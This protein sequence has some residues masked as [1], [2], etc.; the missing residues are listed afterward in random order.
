M[1]VKSDLRFNGTLRLPITLGQPLLPS[2][3]EMVRA[4]ELEFVLRK[5]DYRHRND[6]ATRRISQRTV[7]PGV[8][9]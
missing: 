1:E 2:C 5:A 9:E 6:G 8:L 4:G 7:V 3:K